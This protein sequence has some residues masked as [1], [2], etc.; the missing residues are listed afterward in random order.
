MRSYSST[1]VQSRIRNKVAEV[2]WVETLSG[3]F[4]ISSDFSLKI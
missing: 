1:K 3:N 4:E 2:N